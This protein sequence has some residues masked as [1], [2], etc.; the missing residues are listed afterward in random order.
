MKRSTL[1]SE[2]ELQE[3]ENDERH[4]LLDVRIRGKAVGR[5]RW[6]VLSRVYRYDRTAGRRGASVHKANDL[7]GLLRWIAH[8]P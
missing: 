4:R 6:D 1:Y 8:R 3:V 7:D 2:I 5:I